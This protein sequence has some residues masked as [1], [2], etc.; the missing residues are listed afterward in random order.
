MADRLVIRVR[1]VVRERYAQRARQA[2][3][4]EGRQEAACDDAGECCAPRASAA[5]TCGDIYDAVTL[6]TLPDTVVAAAAGCGNP[7]AL[8]GLRRGERVLDLGSGG[9]IDCFLAG[10]QVGAVGL[11][12]GVDMT[13]DMVA[14]AE[15]NRRKVAARNV[16]FLQAEME[17][18]PLAEGSV[19]VIISNCVINLAPDKDAVFRE[20]FRVLRPGGRVHV[21]D[22]LALAEVPAELR[23]DLRRWAA[24]LAGADPVETYLGRLRAAGFAEVRVVRQ[25]PYRKEDDLPVPLVSAQVEARK[26]GA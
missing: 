26:P 10:R 5:A 25:V 11:V 24:C 1:E 17:H 6:A 3:A 8:A 2:A 13:P 9:G 4:L 18:L 16:L 15:R 23:R 7:T 19:D 22:I 21:A 12:V 14:L 20:A